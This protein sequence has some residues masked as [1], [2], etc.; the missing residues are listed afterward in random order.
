MSDITGPPGYLLDDR[1]EL[2]SPDRLRAVGDPTR[3][4]IAD[5]VL[6]RAMTVTEL[7]ARIGKAKGTVAHHVDML[8]GAGLLKVVSTRKVRAIEERSYGRTARTYV[9]PDSDDDG[10]PF[11][12]E[13]AAQWDRA[14]HDQGKTGGFTL[15]HARISVDRVAE[16][17]AR[18]DALAVEFTELPRDG[19]V[20]YALYLG[21]FP[22]N[23]PVSAKPPAR[24]RRTKGHVDE[25]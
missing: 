7:A 12:A 21:L 1:I 3:M 20:E 11:A 24:R 13:A 10:L 19:D 16:F 2:D 23:R 14:R 15:R 5:L 22:T 25:G 17:G 6:E 4:L 18:L 9:F 8:C